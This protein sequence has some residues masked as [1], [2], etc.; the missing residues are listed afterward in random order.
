MS[1]SKTQKE[2]KLKE[3]IAIKKVKGYLLTEKR[4]KWK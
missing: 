4:E 3:N 2:N 1:L